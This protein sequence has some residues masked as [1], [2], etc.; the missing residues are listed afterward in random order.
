MWIFKIFKIVRNLKNLE[1]KY[2]DDYFFNVASG[3]QS[4]DYPIKL[5]RDC[6]ES[7]GAIF[8]CFFLSTVPGRKS[9]EKSTEVVQIAS[10]FPQSECK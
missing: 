2:F 6:W 4:A 3:V 1:S 9:V 8:S 5:D 10:S 7:N